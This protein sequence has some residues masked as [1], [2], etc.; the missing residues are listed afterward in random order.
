MTTARTIALWAYIGRPQAG[1]EGGIGWNWAQA[2]ARSGHDV[3]LVTTPTFRD[4]LEEQLPT[5]T[6]PCSVTVHF[7]KADDR[8]YARGHRGRPRFKL[9]YLQWQKEALRVSRR[10]GLDAADLGHHA[11]LGSMLPGTRLDQLG[12]PLIFGPVG[13]GRLAF[14]GENTW[15]AK[16]ARL[17]PWF[18]QS[19]SS[20]VT[21]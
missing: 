20:R 11:S 1:S 4:E 13:G 15:H 19:G 7:T 5:Q 17:S 2:R 16:A 9:D 3:H 12:P 21:C 18:P 6:A 8:V 14:A 10:A